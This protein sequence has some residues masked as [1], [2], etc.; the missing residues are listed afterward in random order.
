MEKKERSTY[1]WRYDG[2]PDAR[3]RINDWMD[4]QN[5]VRDSLQMLVLYF[6]D[7]FG[8]KNVMDYEVQKQL[9]ADVLNLL[10][11]SSE[12]LTESREKLS[13]SPP[14]R[15]DGTDSK[16]SELDDILNDVDLKNI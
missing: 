9:Y 12:N 5:N 3:Q 10:P 15:F 8:N 16:S 7:R 11:S 6:A 1:F 14:V 13:S 4:Q 2:D